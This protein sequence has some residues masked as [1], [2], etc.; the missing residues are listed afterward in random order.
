MFRTR[1][2][3][4]ALGCLYRWA[5]FA[6]SST[7]RLTNHNILKKNCPKN[8]PSPSTLPITPLPDVFQ[9]SRIFGSITQLAPQIKIRAATNLQYILQGI[10]Q[11]EPG[12]M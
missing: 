10:F 11:K 8:F 12:R 4:E 1:E 7:S 6:S 5:F 2:L 9:T 3:L